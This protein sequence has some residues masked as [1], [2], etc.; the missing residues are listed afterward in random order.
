M[1]FVVT[2]GNR[3]FESRQLMSGLLLGLI[4]WIEP[5]P[6][7]AEIRPPG[8]AEQYRALLQDWQKY[9][10]RATKEAAEATTDEAK[11]RFSK[12]NVEITHSTGMR[13]LQIA[14]THPMDPAALD[15]LLWIVHTGYE[16]ETG[17]AWRLLISAY[18]GSERLAQACRD[19]RRDVA[20]NPVLAERFLREAMMKSPHREV[21]GQ[22][23]FA[24]AIFL[25][26]RAEVARLCA[27]S[28]EDRKRW[29]SMLKTPENLAL[30]RDR[31]PDD[32]AKEAEG[33]YRRVVAEF[34]DLKDAKGRPLGERAKGEL[35]E[36]GNL[37][38]GKTAPEIEGEDAEGRRFRLSDYRGKVIVLTFSGNWCGPCRA[39]YPAERELVAK[40]RDQ[41]FALL[42]VNTDDSKETLRKSIASGEVTWR[43]WW[44][45]APGGPICTSWGIE[46]FPTVHVLDHRGVIRH[47]GEGGEKLEE[48]VNT[49]LKEIEPTSPNLPKPK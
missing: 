18:L 8:P 5:T 48:V 16:P 34:S 41:P 47:R 37:G 25:N 32:L 42:S 36:I 35:N 43:C 39:M 46:L 49:L 22:A 21:K 3:H 33:I 7:P 1:T 13:A 2:E 20:A 27:A 28:P 31:A 19:T 14:R 4:L 11:K 40:L 12:E 15:A 29:E 26:F 44:D 9:V 38:V 17:E 10:D 30:Y 45:G 23:C 6:V 24:L